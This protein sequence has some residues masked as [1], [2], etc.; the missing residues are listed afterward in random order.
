MIPKVIPGDGEESARQRVWDL[1]AV[2]KKVEEV[3]CS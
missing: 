2:A 1:S 3:V